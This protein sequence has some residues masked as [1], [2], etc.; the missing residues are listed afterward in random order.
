MKT[1]DELILETIKIGIWESN[2]D[3]VPII[4]VIA[5]M[6]EYGKLV[7]TQAL[8]DAADNATIEEIPSRLPY[9][10]S[11]WKINKDSIRSTPILTP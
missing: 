1:A 8:N 10:A 7:A 6:Q 2:L 11:E 5:V 9:S 4:E 3:N